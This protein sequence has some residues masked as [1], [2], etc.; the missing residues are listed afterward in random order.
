MLA[1][2]RESAMTARRH[3]TDASPR[4]HA[5]MTVPFTPELADAP[6]AVGRHPLRVAL[7]TETYPPEVNGV[8]LSVARIADGLHRRGHQVQLVRPRQPTDAPRGATPAGREL[9]VRGMPIPCYPHLRLGLPAADTLRAQ[10]RAQRPDLVH[11]ATEG[12]LGWSALRTARELE[13]AVTS[14]FRT[15]FQAYGAHYRLGWLHGAIL[16]YLRRFHNATGC[17]MVPTEALRAELQERGFERLLVVA[18]G[19]DTGLFDPARRSTRLRQQWGVA[20]DERVLLYVGRLAAE[21]NLELLL[22]AFDA[23]R[24]VAPRLRLVLVGDG[25]LRDALRQR[26]PWAVFAGQRSGTDL[27]AH[28]ASADLFLFPSLTETFGNVTPEAM[29]SGLGV[30]AFDHAAAGQLIEHGRSGWLAP[31]GD[32]AAFVRLAQALARDPQAARRAGQAARDRAMDLD[33]DGV[34]RQVETV[35]VT[36]LIARRGRLPAAWPLARWEPT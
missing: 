27:A 2:L 21:K 25:P 19:V 1:V 13:L 32:S 6:S 8:A 10:W 23:M 34:V 28:Y 26:C 20:A 29:A 14:D 18:R 9:L 16:A 4:Q 31:Y 35:F 33:W 30:L 22:R 5:C 15:N 24:A 7:V 36:A 11:I 3:R 17:T 12:P